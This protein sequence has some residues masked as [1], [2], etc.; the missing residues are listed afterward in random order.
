M[1]G[2]KGGYKGGSRGGG[3]EGSGKG[4]E[5][6][7]GKWRR[8][9]NKLRIRTQTKEHSSCKQVGEQGRAVLTPLPGGQQTGR[10]ERGRRNGGEL[11]APACK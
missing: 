6:K 11:A 7:K 8:G 10:R 1:E 2:G 9:E 5:Q 4:R 3:M